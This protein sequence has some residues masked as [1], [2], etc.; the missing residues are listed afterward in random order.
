MIR[1]IDRIVRGM[2]VQDGA[3]VRLRRL[4]GSPELDY[5]DPFLLLDEFK[6][7]NPDDY[8]AGFPDHPHRGFETVTYL[9]KGRSYHRD[10]T[11]QSWELQ[12]GDVQWMRAGRGVI[13]SE[14]PRPDQ[15]GI[16]G[17]QLWVNL[18]RELKMSPPQ[19]QDIPSKTIPKFKDSGQLVRVISGEFDGLKSPAK[20]VTGITYFDVRL[21]PEASFQY[22][23][24][25]GL[26]CFL[27][28]YEGTLIFPSSQFEHLKAGELA[29]FTGEG[30]ITVTAGDKGAG[31]LFL[32]GKPLHEPVFRGGPFV[33]NTRGEVLQAMEDYQRGRLA[34]PLEEVQLP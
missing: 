34:P 4:L 10:S 6:S 7:E 31:F 2:A 26:N 27:Y 8:M 18:P 13:H 22:Q 30:S 11:G 9:L 28:L 1:Q 15:E 12:P 14:M 3:G 21:D 16:W 19:Y 20:S 33:M 23:P 29:P 5:L 25:P 17:Y 24:P 32:G